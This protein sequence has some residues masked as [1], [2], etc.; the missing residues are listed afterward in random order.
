MENKLEQPA[1]EPVEYLGELANVDGSVNLYF[2]KDQWQGLTDDE[3]NKFIESSKLQ[4]YM[5]FW[6]DRAMSSSM[7][8]RYEEVIKFA[9]AIEQALKE[10][11]HG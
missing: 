3:I 11:N 10:K 1:Q 8:K 5:T 4:D 6:I 7:H 9:R 2:K